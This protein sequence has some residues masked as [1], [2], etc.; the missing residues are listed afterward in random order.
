MNYDLTP[1]ARKQGFRYAYVN[2]WEDKSSPNHCIVNGINRSI[3]ADNIGWE[4][5]ISVALGILK[6]NLEHTRRA[7][8]Q[9]TNEALDCLVRAKGTVLL[10]CDEVQHLATHTEFEDFTAALRTFIDR[11]KDNVR[12]IFT[13]SSQ[14]N[15]NRLFKNQRA[16]FYNSASLTPFPDMGIEFVTFLSQRFQQLTRRP[17]LVDAIFETFAAHYFS[18]AFIVELLQVM[19]RDGFYDLDS[20]LDY[21][22]SL[23]PQETEHELTWS[24]LNALDKAVLKHLAFPESKPLYTQEAY[25]HFTEQLGMLV[26]QGAI[27]ASLKRLRE[28]MFSIMQR[29]VFGTLKMKDS[30]TLYNRRYQ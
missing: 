12:V 14:D 17:L 5:K 16:A 19:V 15:L 8:P 26:G 1:I 28:K 24:H 29:A 6:A 18:S 27:Q 3:Q 21:Y 11:N 30:N 25:A 22:Y 20:G 4:T 10:M 7:S 2:F 23:N 9:C 13:G